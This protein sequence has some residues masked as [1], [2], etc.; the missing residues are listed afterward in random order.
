MLRMFDL[1]QLEKSLCGDCLGAIPWLQRIR[2]PICGRGINCEDCLRRKGR[3]FHYNR[4]SVQYSEEMKG[5]LARYKYRGDEQLSVIIGTM[6]IPA[7]ERLTAAAIG[8][9]GTV[10]AKMAKSTCWDAVTYVPI[11]KERSADRGFNQAQQLAAFIADKYR[12][13]LY[14]LLERELHTEKQSFK[15][16]L[17]RMKGTKGIFKVNRS[18][19]ERLLKES[20]HAQEKCCRILLLDDIYTTGSTVTECSNTLLESSKQLMQIY[21]LTWARS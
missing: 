1:K 10:P 7:F 19:I 2:C 6:L 5:W 3:P 13:P 21:V 18:E 8:N 15:T 20:G 9:V 4:S 14:H 11:S 12:L 17:E 16:R